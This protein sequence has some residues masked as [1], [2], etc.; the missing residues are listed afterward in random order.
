M[1]QEQYGGFFLRPDLGDKGFNLLM[2]WGAPTTHEND[3]D[4][5]LNFILELSLR[6][7]ITLRAGIS[8]RMAYA[9][10]IGSSQ[11]E[12]YTAYGW[13][14]NLAARMMERAGAGEYWMDEE[15]ARRAAKHFNFESAW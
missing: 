8:Y 15:V 11:R 6:T 3:V 4:R 5:A 2:F 7:R 1:L 13:G 12:D 10:F 14:V 9:G